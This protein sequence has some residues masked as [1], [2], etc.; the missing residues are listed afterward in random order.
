VGLDQSCL[1]YFDD[2]IA[3]KPVYGWGWSRLDAPEIPVPNQINGVP[4]PFHCRIKD[5]FYYKGELRG[6]VC[7]IEETEHIYNNH[8]IVFYNRTEG[9]FNFND[10]LPYCNLEIGSS[11]P[12]LKGE[13]HEFTSGSPIV[14]GYAFVGASIKHIE[15]FDA[16]MLERRI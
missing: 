14:N 3:V 10:N 11:I 16:R 8:W 2:L 15:E 4:Y 13:W 5:F 1:I 6:A 7:K 12:Q 9:T